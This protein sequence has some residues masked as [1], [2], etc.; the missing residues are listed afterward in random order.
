MKLTS[1]EVFDTVVNH[2]RKQGCKAGDD[3]GCLYR[4]PNGTKCAAG[5]LIHDDEYLPGIEGGQ[6]FVLLGDSYREYY[7]FWD[8]LSPHKSLISELQYV[9]DEHVV[10][11][12]E[13]DFKAIA[14]N[15]SLIYMPP[16]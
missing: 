8:R 7:A 5:I 4:G 12:W 10:H 9:H 13:T 14:S 11:D 2:L 15:H 3:E 16:Q 1:Q 6:I